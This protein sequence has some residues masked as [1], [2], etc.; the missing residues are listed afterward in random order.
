MRQGR[1]DTNAYASNSA[2]FNS[3]RQPHCVGDQDTLV[4]YF[5]APQ[6]S[7]DNDIIVDTLPFA[8]SRVVGYRFLKPYKTENSGHNGI[9]R[10]TRIHTPPSFHECRETTSQAG[11][12][13]S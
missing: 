9:T 7:W 11:Q 12:P 5:L 10:Q 2:I 8:V 13:H 1:A 3:L 6:F 4:S